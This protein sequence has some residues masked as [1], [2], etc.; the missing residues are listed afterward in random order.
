MSVNSLSS[1]GVDPAVFFWLGKL[2]AK[3]F[4][5]SLY[6]VG[7][8]LPLTPA[9]KGRGIKFQSPLGDAA[10]VVYAERTSV[11][12]MGRKPQSWYTSMVRC[13]VGNTSE[14]SNRTSPCRA[15]QGSCSLFRNCPS[16]WALAAAAYFTVG[17]LPVLV[18][19]YLTLSWG[20]LGMDLSIPKYCWILLWSCFSE[21]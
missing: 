12:S 7:L 16:S 20:F 6:P 14:S 9:L 8:F 17:S 21:T 18:V 5:P 15:W 3:A 19:L 13:P 10:A 11:Q 1:I 2:R 4:K